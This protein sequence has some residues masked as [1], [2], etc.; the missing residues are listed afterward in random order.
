MHILWS[1]PFE[2]SR[3][4]CSGSF[5]S[6]VCACACTPFDLKSIFLPSSFPDTSNLKCWYGVCTGQFTWTLPEL[7]IV[8]SRTAHHRYSASRGLCFPPIFSQSICEPYYQFRS[9]A[10]FPSPC[11][12]RPLVAS[13][14]LLVSYGNVHSPSLF[15][16]VVFWTP[17]FLFFFW[18]KLSL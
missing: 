8:W 2:S 6:R 14:F 3:F 18:H 5:M 12:I 17:P 10:A 4:S 1:F 9:Q 16:H 15:F 13:F 7:A 11:L